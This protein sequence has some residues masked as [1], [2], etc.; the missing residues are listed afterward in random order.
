MHAGDPIIRLSE[1]KD[2]Y[3]DPQVIERTTS[4]LNAKGSAVESYKE[5]VMALDGQITA[6]EQHRG[7]KLQQAVTKLRE[8]KLKMQADSIEYSASLIQFAIA[9]TQLTR[10]EK[11]F[12]NTEAAVGIRR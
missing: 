1:I 2:D 7:L 6:L 4:Q 3:L 10:Q 8:A 5:K 11:L 9:D 12:Q